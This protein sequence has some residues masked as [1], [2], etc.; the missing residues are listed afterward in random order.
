MADPDGRDRCQSLDPR[1][2]P[3]P[4]GAAARTMPYDT[5]ERQLGDRMRRTILAV[6]IPA[7]LVSFLAVSALVRAPRRHH[8]VYVRASEGVWE[9]SEKVS[10]A[11]VVMPGAIVEMGGTGC[12]TV[13]TNGLSSEDVEQIQRRRAL[14]R[15]LEN[16]ARAAVAGARVLSEKQRAIVDSLNERVRVLADSLDRDVLTDAPPRFYRRDIVNRHRRVR[17]RP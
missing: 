17:E 7:T 15:C 16:Y 4:L 2:D 5:G 1:D 14:E 13:G 10:E 11:R 12:V 3:Y 8:T 9:R 6:G